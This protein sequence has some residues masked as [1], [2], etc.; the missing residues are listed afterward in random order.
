MFLDTS[1]FY[2]LLDASEARHTAART[3]LARAV[4]PFTHAYVLAELV[5]LAQIRGLPRSGMLDFISVL[6]ESGEVEVVWPGRELHVTA[7]K[8][9]LARPDKAYSLCDA[10]SFVLMRERGEREALTTD[11][12]FEQEGFVRLLP[13]A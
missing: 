5:P 7:H 13:S 9:L 4:T 2:A 11:H 10:V 12:H 3:E 6:I 8:L 1:G